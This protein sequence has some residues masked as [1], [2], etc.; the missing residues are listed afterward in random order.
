MANVTRPV[1]SL[2][3]PLSIAIGLRHSRE[4]GMSRTVIPHIYGVRRG[5]NLS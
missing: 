3:T 2:W 4:L 1:F 5:L